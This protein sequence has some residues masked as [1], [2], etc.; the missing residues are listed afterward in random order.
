[1]QILC[2]AGA[3]KWMNIRHHIN[4][5][6]FGRFDCGWRGDDDDDLA[7]IYIFIASVALSSSK[8]Q[9]ISRRVIDLMWRDTRVCMRRRNVDKVTNQRDKTIMT[10]TESLEAVSCVRCTYA[11]FLWQ[12]K[13]HRCLIDHKTHIIL[14]LF[15][16][17]RCAIST[18][19]HITY[20]LQRLRRTTRRMSLDPVS[21]FHNFM[22]QFCVARSRVVYSFHCSLF[23]C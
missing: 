3:D 23:V 12:K 5:S 21:S 19:T 11:M 4:Q 1:M 16:L 14:S 17:I 6:I 18:L 8:F 10:F 7:K 2:V 20:C 9:R 15:H 22:E 13:W